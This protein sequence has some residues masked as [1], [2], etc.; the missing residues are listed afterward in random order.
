MSKTIAKPQTKKDGQYELRMKAKSRAEELINVY[1]DLKSEEKKLLDGHKENIKPFLDDY[2][3]KTKPMEDLVKAKLSPIQESMK[4]AVEELEKIGIEKNNRTLFAVDGNWHFE[5]G[6]YLHIKKEAV[7]IFETSTG[8]FEKDMSKADAFDISKF[9]KKFSDYV[10]L[11]FKI[12]ELKALFLDGDSK[13]RKDM[14]NI[15]F[16]LDIEESIEI[17]ESKKAKAPVK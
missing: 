4:A 11:T 2:V 5:N 3:A 14:T 13:L 9:V 6:F 7:P 1:A 15:G 12:K 10:N 8:K 16:D 17:K